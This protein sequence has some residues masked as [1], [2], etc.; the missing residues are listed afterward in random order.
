M[1][2]HY[3][4][5][6]DETGLVYD[7]ARSRGAT[8]WSL[9][10]RAGGGIGQQAEQKV[11]EVAVLSAVE[12]QIRLGD[13]IGDRTQRAELALAC[14][15]RGKKVRDLV[16]MT[17]PIAFGDDVEFL[18]WWSPYAGLWPTVTDNPRQRSS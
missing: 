1:W 8:G 3:F 16:V 14:A 12:A 11:N 10:W 4:L 9:R 5:D 7:A 2:R 15:L 6:I 17:L 13:V 18:G